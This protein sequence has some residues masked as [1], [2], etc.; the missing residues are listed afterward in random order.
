[1]HGRDYSSLRG[2]PRSKFIWDLK[3]ALSH[4]KPSLFV[5]FTWVAIAQMPYTEWL[6]TMDTYLSCFLEAE[7]YKI[8][9]LAEFGVSWESIL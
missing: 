8:K 5:L 9:V 1:M 4:V 3:L 6:V 7:K 2:Q